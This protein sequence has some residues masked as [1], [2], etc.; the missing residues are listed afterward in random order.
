MEQ[1]G[2]DTEELKA[3]FLI[4][5]QETKRKGTQHLTSNNL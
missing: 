3:Q 4:F 5:T 2:N 1:Y